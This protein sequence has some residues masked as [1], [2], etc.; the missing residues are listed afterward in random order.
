MGNLKR[1]AYEIVLVIVVVVLSVALGIGLYSGR[2]KVARSKVLIQEL[3]MI[4]SAVTQFKLVNKKMPESLEELASA[5]YAAGGD[6]RG[7]LSGV[8]RS[9]DGAIVD[10]FGNPYRYDSK[11]GWVD[12]TTEGF[13]RW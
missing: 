5:T 13:E 11:R 2:D 4:R 10:P 1:S 3:A 9:K 8:A 6:K 7:Y 12:S